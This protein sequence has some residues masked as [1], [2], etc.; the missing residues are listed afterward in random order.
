MIERDGPIDA[1][2]ERPAR[3]PDWLDV[4]PSQAGNVALYIET[5]HLSGAVVMSA[6]YA[7]RLAAR[8]EQAADAA[9]DAGGGVREAPEAPGPLLP[10]PGSLGLAEP[11][12]IAWDAAEA[13]GAFLYGA[14]RRA[15]RDARPCTPDTLAAEFPMLAPG[16]LQE[17]LE[18][19]QQ[20]G[21]ITGVSGV[22]G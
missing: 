20:A 8:L 11:T 18:A 13:E 12:A 9:Q 21:L 22:E 2:G 17:S 4:Q 5:D 14:I 1:Q 7:R 3:G 16:V 19:L 10:A 6:A 15:A